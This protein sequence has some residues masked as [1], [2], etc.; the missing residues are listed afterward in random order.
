MFHY[1]SEEAFLSMAKSYKCTPSTKVIQGNKTTMYC[2]KSIKKI[3]K[4]QFS[5]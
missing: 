4:K 1:K 5:I 3:T 2:K